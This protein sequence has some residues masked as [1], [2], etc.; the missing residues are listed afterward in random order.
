MTTVNAQTPVPPYVPPAGN[1]APQ[2]MTPAQIAQSGQFDSVMG[3]S[4]ADARQNA[5]NGKGPERFA[6]LNASNIASGGDGE[7]TAANIAGGP[8][9]PT[10]PQDILNTKSE[11]DEEEESE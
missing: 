4:T 7:I 5:G 9:T 2:A 11:E 8:N 10:G 1:G 3:A 6:G